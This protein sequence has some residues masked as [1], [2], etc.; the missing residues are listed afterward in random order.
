MT[1][2]KRP[3][4]K[5]VLKYL[6]EVGGKGGKA[7]T[8]TSKVRGDHKYYKKVAAAGAKA[9]AKLAEDDPEYYQKIAKKAAATRAKDPTFYKRRSAKAA[10]TRKAN[11]K[12]S[13]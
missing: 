12:K 5:A 11:A 1:D 13:R 3:L 9:R 7:G 2:D 6:Q 4:P 10:A 8:G